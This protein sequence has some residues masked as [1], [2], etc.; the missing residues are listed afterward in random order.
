MHLIKGS[1]LACVLRKKNNNNNNNNELNA[2][3]W[4]RISL[5]FHLNIIKI[6][7]RMST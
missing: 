6:T 4:G 5:Y 7:E 3:R 1:L 2:N